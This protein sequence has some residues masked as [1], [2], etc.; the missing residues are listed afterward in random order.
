MHMSEHGRIVEVCGDEVTRL[1]YNADPGAVAMGK[2]IDEPF[3][4]VAFFGL[5]SSQDVIWAF[6]ADKLYR[7]DENGDAATAP[8][9]AFEQI[10]NIQVSFAMPDFVLV[11]TD[12]N[13]RRSLS[14]STPILVPR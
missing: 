5:A 4:T 7:I 14:D 10:G 12:V 3:E 9:P 8:M 11:L 1:Y 2:G 13:Q 6:G